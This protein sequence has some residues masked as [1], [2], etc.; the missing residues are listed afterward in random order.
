M[1][2]K[3]KSI[4]ESHM[5]NAIMSVVAVVVL[6]EKII[7]QSYIMIIIWIVIN[8]HFITLTMKTR[9]Q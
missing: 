6:I 2:E 3:I 9:N 4:F 5:F 8:Y 1:T 7:N